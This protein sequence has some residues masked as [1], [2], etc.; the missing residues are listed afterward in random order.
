[1]GRQVGCKGWSMGCPSPKF[2]RAVLQH[3][4][5]HLALGKDTPEPRA[6]DPPQCGPERGVRSCRRD[7]LDHGIA[8]HERHLRRLLCEYVHD[9]ED[10]THLGLNKQRRGNRPTAIRTEDCRAI[11]RPSRSVILACATI[12]NIE[13]SG[14]KSYFNVGFKP[15][16]CKRSV[17]ET[18]LRGD[19]QHA[20]RRSLRPTKHRSAQCVISTF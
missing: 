14:G 7:L 12:F 4:T 13:R 15:F 3:S 17:R 18:C 20:G 9:Y 8:L 19:F 16:P 6:V 1:M 11:S 10:H 2:G 5:T